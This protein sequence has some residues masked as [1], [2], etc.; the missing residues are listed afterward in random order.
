MKH[1]LVDLPSV[2]REEDGGVLAAHHAFWDYPNQLDRVRTIS[3]LLHV[4]T[5]V[6]DGEYLLEMQLPHFI[7]DA[8]P[9]RSILYAL[10][11]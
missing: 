2:D 8:A 10:L 1:L 7:N 4:P 6:R 3:E 9:S 5:D 11:S